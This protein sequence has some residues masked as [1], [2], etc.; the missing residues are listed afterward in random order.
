MVTILKPLKIRVFANRTEGQGSILGRVKPKIQK[1]VL[2]V[3][4]FDTQHY[5]VPIKRKW[6]NPGKGVAPF[7][8][9][10]SSSY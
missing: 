9:P 10:R 4:V 6:S 7:P 3:F 2:D 8:T 1:M 5:T